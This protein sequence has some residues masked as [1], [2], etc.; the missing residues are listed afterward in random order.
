ML[1]TATAIVADI[2]PLSPT[3]QDT[4][5]SNHTGQRAIKNVLRTDVPSTCT[6]IRGAYSAI[7]ALR[8]A[9]APGDHSPS[10]T[11]CGPGLMAAVRQIAMAAHHGASALVAGE[12]LQ[13]IRVY[14]DPC[15][16]LTAS[17]YAGGPHANTASETA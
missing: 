8:K 10:V 15:K 11:G 3:Q 12:A 17:R 1:P 2:W 4:P 16:S 7:C 5:A 14:Q 6:P 9:V 13:R